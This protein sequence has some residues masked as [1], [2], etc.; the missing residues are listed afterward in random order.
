[1]AFRPSDR[2]IVIQEHG[3]VLPEG[4]TN[5]SSFYHD[6]PGADA[7]ARNSLNHVL[8]HEV[9]DALYRLGH[10]DMHRFTI[11]LYTGGGVPPIPAGFS[12]LMLNQ[13]YVTDDDG[14]F[15]VVEN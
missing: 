9:Q 2:S 3:D 8:Y 13:A 15:I 4:H 10:Q 12:F 14:R 6:G 5:I 7:F 11:T 1:M